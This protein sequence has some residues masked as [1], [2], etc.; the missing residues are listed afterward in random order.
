MKRFLWVLVCVIALTATAMSAPAVAE[1]RQKPSPT[2][3]P[4]AY[5]CESVGL[6]PDCQPV[7]ESS[8]TGPVTLAAVVGTL[9]SNYLWTF[10]DSLRYYI[11]DS[12]GA[13]HYIGTVRVTAKINLNGRQSQWTQTTQ[14]IAG[15]AIK[16]THRW[17]C[18]DDNGSFLNSE[19]NEGTGSWPSHTDTSYRSSTFTTYRTNFHSQ[20]ETYW[21]DF[22]YYW[23]ASGWSG[24]Q[25]YSGR[26]TSYHFS[27]RN[28]QTNPC[29]F[30]W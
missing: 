27:C 16:A 3:S 13:S 23:L 2:P 12:S 8:T 6:L 20:T 9:Q 11:V 10:N 4:S 5:T 29:R 17:N 21:Y 26:G 25:W 15:P 22:E 24:I 18:V 7:V 14:V 30:R 1:A 19:C 28:V